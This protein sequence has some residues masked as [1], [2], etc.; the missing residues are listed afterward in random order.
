MTHGPHTIQFQSNTPVQENR[1]VA[2][3]K[4]NVP[5]PPH[6]NVFKTFDYTYLA[7]V[8][9]LEKKNPYRDVLPHNNSEKYDQYNAFTIKSPKEDVRST[10][11]NELAKQNTDPKNSCVRD[12]Y[13][14]FERHF[15]Q[16]AFNNAI[17]NQRIS[18]LKPNP[19]SLIANPGRSYNNSKNKILI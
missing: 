18:S 14:Q 13:E 17:L 9:Q 19:C 3:T 6:Q 8:N 2:P 15:S 16:S 5:K 12:E 11:S 4:P 1:N 7:P 10:I